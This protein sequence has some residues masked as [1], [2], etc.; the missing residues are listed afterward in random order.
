MW[1][2]NNNGA[3]V[4]RR[5]LCA[6]AG[7]GRQQ[8]RARGPAAEPDQGGAGGVGAEQVPGCGGCEA[9]HGE[10]GGN[11]SKVGTRPMPLMHCSMPLGRWG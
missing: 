3:G 2:G 1:R 10:L 8:G 11:L 5:V 9:E 7:L 6:C 4:V